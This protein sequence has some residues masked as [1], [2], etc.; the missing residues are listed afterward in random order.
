MS[1]NWRRHRAAVE[2][3]AADV[4]LTTRR[5]RAF[6]TGLLARGRRLVTSGKIVVAVA[7]AG[8]LLPP[9]L[10]RQRDTDKAAEHD[11]STGLLAR[12]G[13]LL[14]AVIRWRAL[15]RDAAELLNQSPAAQQPP[16]P[17]NDT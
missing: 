2:Q 4:A 13:M 1:L 15:A 6:R 7:L 16:A 5:E 3:L 8:F 14:L 9:L 12:A 17:A 10:S 11:Q